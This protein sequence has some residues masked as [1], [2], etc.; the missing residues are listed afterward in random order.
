MNVDWTDFHLQYYAFSQ[1][2]QYTWPKTL[3]ST[4]SYLV[5]PVTFKIPDYKKKLDND[6]IWFSPLFFAIEGECITWLTVEFYRS[7]THQGLLVSLL[8][9]K[10]YPEE[11]CYGTYNT[12]FTIEL[13][14]QLYNSDHYV[15]LLVLRMTLD[16]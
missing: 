6:E 5:A 10:S 2:E 4:D 12:M 14:N 1:T 13:L 9:K 8:F 3:A 11:T 15:S 7:E 16:M